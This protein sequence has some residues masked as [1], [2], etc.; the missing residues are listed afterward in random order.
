MGG[1]RDYHLFLILP[2]LS[3]C[4]EKTERGE[5]AKS[6][7]N[8]GNLRFNIVVILM[9]QIQNVEQTCF[10]LQSNHSILPKGFTQTIMFDSR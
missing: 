9:E 2:T 5:R 10:F 7:S 6:I 1:F 8:R 3:H 4:P